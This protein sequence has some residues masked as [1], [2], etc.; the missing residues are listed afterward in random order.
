MHYSKDQNSEDEIGKVCGM[1]GK[2]YGC[3]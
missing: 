3:I 2:E 1:H